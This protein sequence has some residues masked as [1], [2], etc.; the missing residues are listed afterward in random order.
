MPCFENLQIA[1]GVSYRN[2]PSNCCASQALFLSVAVTLGIL[3]GERVIRFQ[4]VHMHRQQSEKISKMFTLPAPRQNFAEMNAATTLPTS[5]FLR[6][7][8]NCWYFR[9]TLKG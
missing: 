5:N 2:M 1:F 7:C 8:E 3:C 6:F 4:N 9:P